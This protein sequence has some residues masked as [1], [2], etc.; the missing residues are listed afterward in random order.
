[1]GLLISLLVVTITIGSLSFLHSFL[2]N[3]GL[4]LGSKKGSDALHR[5]QQDQT[6]FSTEVT[7][8]PNTERRLKVYVPECQDLELYTPNFFGRP[9]EVLGVTKEADTKA[10]V[11]AHKFWLKE[12][13]PDH[14][15]PDADKKEMQKA[16]FEAQRLNEARNLMLDARKK[17]K[18][19]A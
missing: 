4:R 17:R 9:H 11:V 14:M 3:L 8:F 10:I 19:A 6:P 7:K 13:H 2:I 18:Q 1:M 16:H 12:Y 5:N 15:S